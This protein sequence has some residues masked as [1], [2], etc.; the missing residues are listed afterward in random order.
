M[1]GVVRRNLQKCYCAGVENSYYVLPM[2]FPQNSRAALGFVAVVLSAFSPVAFADSG[3]WTSTGSSTSWST[4]GNWAGSVVANGVS[5][6]A[7][8]SQANS[9]SSGA[10]NIVLDTNVILGNFIFGDMTGVNKGRWTLNGNGTNTLTFDNGGSTSILS[11]G[12]GSTGGSNSI[13]N[14][15][16]G[17]AN[18]LEINAATTTAGTAFVISGS[19]ISATT[20]GTKTIINT[21]TGVTGVN[22]SSSIRD[23]AGVVAVTQNS[24]T[25][26]LT[27]TGSNSFT[28][29]VNI[30]AGV[31]TIGNANA[32]GASSSI[33]LVNGGTLGMVSSTT[34]TLAN[35][36]TI[37]A[38]GATLQGNS[39]SSLTLTG[40]I[41][42]VGNLTKAGNSNVLTLS[43]SNSY[44]G[45]TAVALGT[46]L[47]N[48]DQSAATGNVTV[49]S[50]ATLGGG[51]TIGGATTVADGGVLTPGAAVGSSMAVLT[52]ANGLTLGGDATSTVLEIAG[53]SRGV[54]YDAITI[55]A[56]K[57]LVYD[58]VL[59]LNITSV[60]DGGTYDLFHF[61][62]G[63]NA[64]GFD[65]LVFSGGVY[66]GTFVEITNG[67]W[68]ATSGLQTLTFT[69]ASGDLLVVPEPSTY[70]LLAL[71]LTAIVVLRRRKSQEA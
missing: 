61:T 27:L 4:A 37:G 63:L 31:L 42:G 16:I 22:I 25:S 14:I 33:I 2:K 48:G 17:L 3:T 15:T 67:V 62:G 60:L 40:N 18:S 5:A 29:G 58:G 44:S 50:G 19:S 52:F 38:S 70:V 1:F 8:F 45:T 46:L 35:N 55:G 69:E 47:V 24:T 32:L 71:G 10:R 51:G 23:G 41:S 39:N 7:D 65:S 59:T 34:V 66:S 12:P 43:G 11:T 56:G 54:S 9:A 53:A 26:S 13:N 30:N 57:S 28:G 20:A 21:G 64:G 36:V 68:Q 49:N 6:T